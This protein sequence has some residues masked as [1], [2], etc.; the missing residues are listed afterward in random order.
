MVNFASKDYS[1]G[2]CRDWAYGVA[3]VPLSYTF[4]LPGAGFGFAPPAS[5]IIPVVTETWE[6]VKVLASKAPLAERP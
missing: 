3:G 2:A 1:Y 5:T 4:E 6:A